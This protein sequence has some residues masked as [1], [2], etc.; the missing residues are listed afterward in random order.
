VIKR[1]AHGLDMPDFARATLGLAPVGLEPP[2][3]DQ[4][5]PDLPPA[6]ESERHPRTT[7]HYLISERSDSYDELAARLGISSRNLARLARDERGT[8]PADVQSFTRRAIETYFGQTLDHLLRPPSRHD[9][10]RLSG[11]RADHGASVEDD[12]YDRSSGDH[13]GA[14]VDRRDLLRLTASAISATLLPVAPQVRPLGGVAGDHRNAGRPDSDSDAESLARQTAELTDLY[15]A[16]RYREAVDR[17]P[18]LIASATQLSRSATSAGSATL[19]AAARAFQL[20]GS[21]MLK[22][23]DVGFAMLV[24]DRSMEAATRSSDPL[25][26]LS[27]ARLVAQVLMS[28]GH[29]RAALDACRQIA[30]RFEP[31]YTSTSTQAIS[32]YGALLLRAAVAAARLND[33]ATTA[34]LLAEATDA[35]GRLGRDGNARATAF[36]PTNVLV[37]KAHAALLL[38]DAGFAINLI[39]K[40]DLTKLPLPERKA[41]VHED[42]ARAY[43]QWGK[44]EPAYEALRR[45]ELVAPEELRG[46]PTIGRLVTELLLTAP[47]SMRRPLQ[48]LAE[49]SAARSAQ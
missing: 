43:A 18:I 14:E 12:V 39:D 45:L 29:P 16:T 37:H 44:H 32:V 35:A 42:T 7:L 31:N 3:V 23:G 49:R 26:Q 1:I 27:S 47:P 11:S 4:D 33:R 25:T 19:S 8:R 46:R 22:A 40:I 13:Q 15:Q 30:E 21:V 38:G 6:A 36:G 9:L 20:S 48:E 24:A 2:T 17:L 10:A 5:C 41:A 34:Q 28:A